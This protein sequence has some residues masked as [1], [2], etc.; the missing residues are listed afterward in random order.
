MKNKKAFT[1]IEILVVVAI[2]VI[3]ATVTLLLISQATKNSRI[4]SA[5]TSVRSAL[6]AVSACK[7]MNGAVSTPSGSE[8]GAR[9]ICT[10][11]GAG[12]PSANWPQLSNGYQYSAG[13]YDSV[14]CTFP[15]STNGDVTPLGNT[16][17]TCNCSTQKCE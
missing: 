8:N 12:L 15:V 1:L 3:L 14:N 5:K 11:A 6:L 10:T 2:I 4:S 7:N 16:F 17:L 9:L 13:T